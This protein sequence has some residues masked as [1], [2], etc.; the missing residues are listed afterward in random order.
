MQKKIQDSKTVSGFTS[1]FKTATVASSNKA[2]SSSMTKKTPQ[3]TKNTKKK[4]Q[5]SQYMTAKEDQK[6]GV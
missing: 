2:K 6:G 3:S 5:L 4:Q 1:S